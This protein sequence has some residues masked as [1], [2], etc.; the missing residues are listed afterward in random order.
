MEKA[1]WIKTAEVY[2]RCRKSGQT[3]AESDLLQAGFCLQHAY[4]LVTHNTNHF[5]HIT[6]L[7]LEDWVT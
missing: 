4:V 6:D 2:A 7:D 3:M 1:D 5:C